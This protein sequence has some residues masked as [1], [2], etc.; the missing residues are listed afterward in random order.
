MSARR[1]LGAKGMA[2]PMALGS[3]LSYNRTGNCF[4]NWS[5]DIKKKN[6]DS[7]TF[8]GTRRVPGHIGLVLSV[9]M[10]K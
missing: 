2:K 6:V 8:D 7:Y 5:G 9:L 10:G 1:T 3:A 4:S